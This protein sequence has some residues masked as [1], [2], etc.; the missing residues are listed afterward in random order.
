M[1]SS[2]RRCQLIASN[3]GGTSVHD[4]LQYAMPQL[5]NDSEQAF[6]SEVLSPQ[7]TDIGDTTSVTIAIAITA[8]AL[9]HTQPE[10]LSAPPPHSGQSEDAS[11]YTILSRTKAITTTASFLSLC[12]YLVIRAS[13]AM[14][15]SCESDCD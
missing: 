1:T 3:L 8:A 13:T 14:R 4:S 12:L 5:L 15:V 6:D 9:D 10:A 7:V 11:R 2:F